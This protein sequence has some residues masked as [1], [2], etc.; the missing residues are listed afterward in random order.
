MVQATRKTGEVLLLE[1]PFFSRTA[2]DEIRAYV[3]SKYNLALLAL[4]SYLRAN[5]DFSV[6]L[7]NMVKD[8]LSEDALIETL[9]ENPPA[10]VGI[11]LYSY[12]LGLTYKIITRI[13]REF[14]QTHIC[15]GGPHTSIF[16]EET[17]RLPHVDSMVLGDGE[18][19]FLEVC[20]QVIE[21]GRLDPQALPPGTC[22]KES[23]ADGRPLPAAY[24]VKD[25]DALPLPDLS[26]LG[27]HT[28]Y[29]DFLSNKIMAILTTSRGCPFVCQY[30]WSEK[31]KYR[32][33]SIERMIDI[34]RHYKESGVEYIEFWDETFNP[35][36]KRLNDFADA[37]LAAD[38]NLTWSIRGAVVQHVPLETMIKLKKTGLRIMQFGVETGN[39]RLLK[40]LNKRIDLEKIQNAIDTCRQAGVRSV[41]NMMINIPGETR[42]ELLADFDM[43]ARIR[44]TYLSV[45]VYNW[46]PGTTHYENAI[47]EG[48][49]PTDFWRQHA[50]NPVE[51]E[52]PVVHPVTEVPVEEIYKLRDRFVSRY[53]FNPRYVFQYARMLDFSEAK[54]AVEIALLMAKSRL[55]SV[56]PTFQ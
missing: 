48:V 49:L 1:T 42:Q 13:K 47:K 9:R 51:E 37:L 16:P 53:Y 43:L 22:T 20:R 56:K 8:Q 40:Y 17:L 2:S 52:D 25:L 15:I 32:S 7:I 41:A 50:A 34:M 38:L 39:D 4:G 33:F 54:R 30:C 6:R 44:P 55:L 19:P 10:V 5:S 12:N 28:R 18:I 14:P 23:Q 24:A 46:A 29:R 26:L 31:S 35:T 36:K 11:P 27:D 3:Q 45:S 21:R